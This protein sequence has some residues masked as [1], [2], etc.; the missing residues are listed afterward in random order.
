M[1]NLKLLITSIIITTALIQFNAQAQ[2]NLPLK[3]R[4]GTYNVGHFNQGEPG[5][6]SGKQIEAEMQQWRKWIGQQSLDIFFMS[7]WNSTFDQNKTLNATHELLKPFYNNIAFGEEFTWIHNGI[8]TN[9]QLTNVRQIDL[10]HKEYYALAADL[11]LGNKTI[12]LMS[13]HVPWQECCHES[14]LQMLIDEMKKYE[15]VICAGDINAS[16]KNQLRFVSEGFNMANGGNEGWFCTW[17]KD[18]DKEDKEKYNASLDNI[19]TS[20]NIK[21][22]NVS[23]PQNTMTDRDHWPIV[24][25]IVI[26][27][28]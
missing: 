19:I 15:Y 13:V 6:Y 5:G 17:A 22:F 20:K 24:A 25:D 8:A 1:K 18:C 9:Y 11:I 14:S 7:E 3:L 10:T 21:I 26:T 2:N 4:V 16:N 28:E 27:E 12:T 23:A